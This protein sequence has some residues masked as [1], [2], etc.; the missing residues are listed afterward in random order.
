MQQPVVANRGLTS[1][2]RDVR[3]SQPHALLR[4]GLIVDVTSLEPDLIAKV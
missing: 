4:C 1:G 2:V 3:L